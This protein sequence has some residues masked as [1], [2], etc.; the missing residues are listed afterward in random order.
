[1]QV[2]SLIQED[3]LEKEMA[4]H[5]SILALRIPWTEEPGMLQSMGS[6][7]IGYDW[8]TKQACTSLSKLL[9][10]NLTLLYS[11]CIGRHTHRACCCSVAHHVW[12]F[13]TLLTGIQ[14]S[15]SI[16]Y[17]ACIQYIWS[18]W[19]CLITEDCMHS[20]YIPGFPGGS[21]GKVSSC[22]MGAL[23]SIPGLG[24]SPREVESYPLQ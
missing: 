2:W 15:L 13:A 12:L 4:I 1:M 18:I 21:A 17:S 11:L 10:N 6:Q 19:G 20:F 22:N 23:G 8:A 9:L 24:R 7:R 3:P 14:A 5:S 16:V